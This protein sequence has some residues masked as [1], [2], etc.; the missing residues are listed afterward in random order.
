[1][2]PPIHAGGLRY[3]G[4][5]PLVSHLLKQGFIEA[6][7]Y[8][9]LATFEAGRAASPGPRASSAPR[10]PTTPSRRPSRRL[11]PRRTAKKVHPLQPQ[12]GHGHFDM[13]A[14]DAYL[15]G[16]LTDVEYEPE[17]AREAADAA[18]REA[19]VA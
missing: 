16:K 14:Y 4:M 2:P 12:S 19:A 15:A 9:Q 11:G 7:A 18:P 10:R 5:A 3:H 13:A 17:P 6:Q 1:M 8:N